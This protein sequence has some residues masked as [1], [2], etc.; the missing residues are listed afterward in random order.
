MQHIDNNQIKSNIP[1]ISAIFPH[2]IHDFIMYNSN[3]SIKTI[4]CHVK[5]SW[6]MLIFALKLRYINYIKLFQVYLLIY[7][8]W[9]Y[10]RML[11]LC[12]VVRYRLPL[13]FILI[14][15]ILQTS[16]V[17]SSR[18]DLREVRISDV[19]PTRTRY[20]R[21]RR[22]FIRIIQRRYSRLC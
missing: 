16:I 5:T 17:P 4:C 7:F 6:F 15:D 19:Y 20:R 3:A 22:L 18:S 12:S 13:I 9:F 21:G 8:K 11:S 1:N 14:V 10:V 2:Q